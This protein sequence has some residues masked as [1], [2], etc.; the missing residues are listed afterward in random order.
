MNQRPRVRFKGSNSGPLTRL[1][2]DAE[3][4]GPVSGAGTGWKL[5]FITENN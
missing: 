4:S 5:Y 1:L 2:L 3:G